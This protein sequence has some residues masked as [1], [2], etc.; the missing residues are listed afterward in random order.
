[1]KKFSFRLE[2]NLNLARQIENEARIEHQSF[3][4]ERDRLAE[5]LAILN[6]RL[7]LLMHSIRNLEGDVQ[8]IILYKDYISVTRTAIQEKEQELDHAEIL[9]EKSRLNL[10][11]KSRETKTLDK[12]KEREWDEYILENN[13]QE[14]KIIDEVAVNSYFRKN[15]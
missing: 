9:L 1:M 12:L 13:R 7:Q 10:V 6:Q 5:Q 8:E 4:R 2:K 11:E 15:F 14:Q 3:L